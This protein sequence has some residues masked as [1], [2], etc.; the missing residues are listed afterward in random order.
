MFY[1]SLIYGKVSRQFFVRKSEECSHY[2]SFFSDYYLEENVDALSSERLNLCTGQI[3]SGLLVSL[4][5]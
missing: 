3:E 2:C 4:S 5:T 1:Y